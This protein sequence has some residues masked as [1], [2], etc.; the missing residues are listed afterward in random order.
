MDFA[1]MERMQIANH[2]ITQFLLRPG[3][4]SIELCSKN[5]AYML[6]SIVLSWKAQINKSMS[7]N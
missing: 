6:T 4:E 3:F 5:Y 1:P 7:V 2:F